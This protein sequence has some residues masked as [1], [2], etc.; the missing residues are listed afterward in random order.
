M[1]HTTAA[2]PEFDSTAGAGAILWEQC[3]PTI[4]AESLHRLPA[5]TFFRNDRAEAQTISETLADL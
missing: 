5:L 2:Y 3:G 4:S 1:C